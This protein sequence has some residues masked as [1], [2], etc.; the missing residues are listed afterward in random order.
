M[1]SP[2][3]GNQRKEDATS[4]EVVE[5]T[6][7]RQLMGSHMY[8]VNTRSNMCYEVNQLSQTMVKSTKLYW[9]ATKHVL[10]CLRGTT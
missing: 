4:S 2:L 6:I 7:Y 1:E 10:R 5:A 3:D 9:K 8:F